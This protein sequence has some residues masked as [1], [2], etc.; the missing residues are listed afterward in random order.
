[1]WAALRDPNLWPVNGKRRSVREGRDAD[2]RLEQRA[3]ML[4]AIAGARV[5]AWRPQ[6]EAVTQSA[7]AKLADG[8][9]GGTAR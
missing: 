9:P 8:P 7:I 2:G 4:E 5:E 6:V 1:M 3:P